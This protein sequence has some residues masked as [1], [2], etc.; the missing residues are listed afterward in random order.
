MD[1][2]QKLG[3]DSSLLSHDDL[4][5]LEEMG[6]SIRS[7]MSSQQILETLKNAGIDVGSLVKKMKGPQVPKKSV[8]I[9]RNQKC[10][11]GSGKKYKKCCYLK[12]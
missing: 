7:N 12:R 8:R 3:L 4:K 11:C 9:G 1:I 2:L 10:I 6:K 5:S